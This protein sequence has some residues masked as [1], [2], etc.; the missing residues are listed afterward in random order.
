VFIPA[1]VAEREDTHHN[2]RKQGILMKLH[3]ILA[4]TLLAFSLA[5]CAPTMQMGQG[6]TLATGSAGDAGAQ[7]AHS[8]LVRCN[9]MLGTVK[10]EDNPQPYGYIQYIGNGLNMPRSPLPLLK[11]ILQQTGCF[12]IVDHS[13]RGLNNM[14]GEQQLQQAGLVRKQNNVVKGNFV[15]A[16]YTLIP[17]LAFSNRDAGGSGANIAGAVLGHFAPQVGFLAGSLQGH[18]KVKEAQVVLSL[19]DNNT[20]EQISAAEGSATSSD[21]SLDGSLLSIFAGAGGIGGV[22]G[23]AGGWSNTPESKVVVAAF[24]DAINKIVP[25]FRSMAGATAAVPEKK[26]R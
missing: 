5:A 1:Y 13:Q 9:E 25:Q 3:S 7:G 22:G 8:S 12:R 10:L 20:S 26:R 11:L 6:G 18:T 16:H 17:D 21:Y 24:V 19:V 15:E 4:S 2:A 23:G 14:I